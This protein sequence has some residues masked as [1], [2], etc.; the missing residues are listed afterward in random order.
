MVF[1]EDNLFIRFSGIIYYGEILDVDE[2]LF[3]F[4]E[5]FIVF[6]WLCLFYFNFL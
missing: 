6:I 1:I 4:F 3:L 2:E 5:N